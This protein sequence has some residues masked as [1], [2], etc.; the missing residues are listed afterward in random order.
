MIWHADTETGTAT[1]K[2][3]P[4]RKD[5][6]ST[7]RRHRRNLL[8]ARRTGRR[9]GADFTE[10]CE[11]IGG[12]YLGNRQKGA[13]MRPARYLSVFLCCIALVVVTVGCDDSD[14]DSEPASEPDREEPSSASDTAAGVFEYDV[15]VI[16][17][18]QGQPFSPPV[19]A[20][21]QDED[22]VFKL[23][24]P[25][26]E[27]VKQIAE[28]GNNRPLLELLHD[29]RVDETVFD[30][31]Q[32]PAPLV[33]QGTPGAEATAPF[34]CG[35]GC[36]DRWTARIRADEAH[37]RISW[38]SMLVCTNDGFTGVGGVSLPTEIG[39]EMVIQTPAYET[40]TERNTE[41]LADIMPPCQGLI[42]VPSPSG[43]PGTAQSNPALAESGNILPHRGVVGGNELD[44]AV[45]GWS[46]PAGKILITRL[47]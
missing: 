12:Y 8:S 18:T 2:V 26:S 11:Q 34:P 4:I 24:Q 37:A 46:D 15:T 39:E 27:A 40:S 10:A 3:T 29:Q 43:A 17:L 35:G 5:G 6:S 20:T 9:G 33:P 13:E 32:A 31:A 23:S 44:P 7:A 42:G 25:S 1:R 41:V 30:F 45:H 16:N 47:S 28:N 38:V 21:H 22:D 19:V 14:S 36:P